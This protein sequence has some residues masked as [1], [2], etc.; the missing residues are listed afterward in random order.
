MAANAVPE[1]LAVFT[2]PEHHRRRLRTSDLI[3]PAIRQD[4]QGSRLRPGAPVPRIRCSRRDR[5]NM[6]FHNKPVLREVEGAYIKR[7]CRNK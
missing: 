2:L 7:E 3:E 5:P 1:G 4:L 6:G